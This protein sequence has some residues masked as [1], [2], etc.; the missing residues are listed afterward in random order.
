MKNIALVLV[1][2]SLFAFSGLA[3]AA[4]ETAA[5][6]S[7][8]ESH[9]LT[10]L[11]LGNEMVGIKPAVG[12]NVYNDAAG[13]RSLRASYGIAAEMNAAALIG[14]D[15]TRW[16]VGPQTGFT[17]SHLGQASSNWVGTNGNGADAGANL[18]L[19]PVNLKAAVAPTSWMRAG[20]HG[21]GNVLYRS[22]A[23]SIRIDNTDLNWRMIPNIGADIDFAFGKSVALSIR[24]DW[25]LSSTDSLF[26]A[27]A[28]LGITL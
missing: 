28:A 26:S 9:A 10:R 24:P 20:V 14:A 2:A 17:F 16:F 5:P 15:Y 21:G 12:F 7:T 13:S 1:S 23:S 27:T 18:V 22:I 6:T 4:D 3:L 8:Q 19:I 25:T 11:Y